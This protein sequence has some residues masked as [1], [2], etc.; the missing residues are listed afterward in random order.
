MRLILRAFA[1]RQWRR[2]I[3]RLRLLREHPRF[4]AFTAYASHTF[5]TLVRIIDDRLKRLLEIVINLSATQG[6][7]DADKSAEGRE[8]REHNQ[9][10]GHHPGRFV[11]LEWAM[12]VSMTAASRM[13]RHVLV[14]LVVS[15]VNMLSRLVMRAVASRR[16]LCVVWLFAFIESM[17]M[18]FVGLTTRVFFRESLF[19]PEGHDH[20]ARHV[21]GGQ[22]SSQR[23]DSPENL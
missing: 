5:A 20:Q 2:A 18:R 12:P 22:K 17:R 9:R 21:D 19:A 16:K 10:H 6:I 23:A 7:R 11:R 1:N 3:L 14:M 8:N 13:N 15:F 4:R